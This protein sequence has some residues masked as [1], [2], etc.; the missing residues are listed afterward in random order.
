[1]SKY[2]VVPLEQ[3]ETAY[4]SLDAAKTAAKE[5]AETADLFK[6]WAVIEVIHHGHYE[7]VTPVWIDPTPLLPRAQLAVNPVSTNDDMPF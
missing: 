3:L 2:L 1:M 6:S 4:V 5:S 7:K